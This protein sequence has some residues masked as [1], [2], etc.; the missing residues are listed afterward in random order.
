[1]PLDPARERLAAG[2]TGLGSS[3]VRGRM[4]GA[5]MLEADPLP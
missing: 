5:E 1:M 3:R 4:T 2:I